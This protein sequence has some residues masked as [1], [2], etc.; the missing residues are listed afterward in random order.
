MVAA[1]RQGIEIVVAAAD[2]DELIDAVIVR[3]DVFITD[4]PGDFPAI[5]V[6][7]REIEVGV[8]QRDTSPHVSLA[9]T[10]P[11]ADQVEG[12]PGQGVIRL[13]AGIEEELRRML[14]G[15]K[16]ARRFPGFDM[17]PE[18]RAIELGASVQH[19]HVE[20]L[21]REVPGGHSAGR[22]RTDDDDIVDFLHYDWCSGWVQPLNSERKVLPCQPNSSTRPAREE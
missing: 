11:D 15:G 9:A 5:A 1:A 4:G 18:L 14:S 8:T 7:A 6:G 21:A 22:A 10:S 16:F 19:E 20:A 13:L 3:C 2:A 17:A 12:L